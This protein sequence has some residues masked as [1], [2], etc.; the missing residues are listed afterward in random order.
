ML[1]SITFVF[2]NVDDITIDGKY[3]ECFLLNDFQKIISF[4]QRNDY[5]EMNVA[6]HFSIKINHAANVKVNEFHDENLDKYYV[7]DRL[8]NI[9]DIVWIEYE[10][11]DG[12]GKVQTYKYYVDWNE[13]NDYMNSNQK[14]CIDKDMNLCIVVDSKKGLQDIFD[15]L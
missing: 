1:K 9:K 5:S 7:F 2:E 4:S 12:S 13:S 8:S 14:S 6:G 10:I 3:V 15:N 11:I